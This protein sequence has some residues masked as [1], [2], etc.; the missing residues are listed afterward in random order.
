L[1]KPIAVTG[2]TGLLGGY[3]VAELRRQSFDVLAFGGPTRGGGIDLGDHAALG[4]VADRASAVIHCAAL[5][6]MADC[7]RD[8]ERA[9]RINTEG[10][11][12]VARACAK[13]KTRLVHVSTDLVFDGEHAPYRESDA[14]F[15]VSV[16]GKT[17]LDAETEALAAE[18]ARPIVVR[19][20]LLFGPTRT[21]RKGFFDSQLASF[22]AA[23]SSSGDADTKP[24][25]LFDDEWRTPLSLRAAAEGLVALARSS[26][27]HTGILH[28]AG[29]ERLS[30]LAM[31]VRLRDALGMPPSITI[32]AGSR[33]GI[34]GEP[35]PRDVSLDSTAFHAAFPNI[36]TLTFEAEVE[37][38]M[39]DR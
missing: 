39:R 19:I 5:S 12:N 20:S 28:L 23:A 13:H 37:R 2:A 31:G 10:T 24:L 14:P 16:Y 22:E 25:T 4:F 11:S 38:M 8:P 15:P 34:P 21:D 35:R 33:L 36:G 9:A 18:D 3:V 26:S 27:E 6:A 29:P 7:V 30:R 1:K 17:K 32:Q